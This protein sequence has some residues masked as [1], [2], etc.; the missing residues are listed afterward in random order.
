DEPFGALD[1]LTRAELQGE[2]ARL[3]KRLG[4]TV[5]LVTHDLREALLLGTQIALLDAGRL[6]GL[7]TPAEFM[8]TADLLAAAYRHAFSAQD[9]GGD[10]A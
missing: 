6:I 7:Y 9:A 1:P 2:F 4:K 8:R 5:V 10:P 3:Q